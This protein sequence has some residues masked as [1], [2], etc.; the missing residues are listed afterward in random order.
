M[1]EPMDADEALARAL[2]VE[3]DDDY[4]EDPGMF[5]EH[6]AHWLGL[7]SRVRSAGW[8]PGAEV[9]RLREQHGTD[10]HNLMQRQLVVLHER[11]ALQAQLERV[12]AVCAAYYDNGPA[13]AFVIEKVRAALAPQEATDG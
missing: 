1:P 6:R 8:V 9:E 5:R 12:E 10:V 4:Y 13:H 2:A 3:T 11:D 7:V